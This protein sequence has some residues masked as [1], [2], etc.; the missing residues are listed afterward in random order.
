M[1]DVYLITNFGLGK[2]VSPVLWEILTSLLTPNGP[3]GK[4]MQPRA[5]TFALTCKFTTFPYY[6]IISM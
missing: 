4:L 5:H 2:R 1:G 3:R 6:V